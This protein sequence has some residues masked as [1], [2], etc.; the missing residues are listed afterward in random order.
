MTTPAEKSGL[1]KEFL[2]YLWCHKLACLL[3]LILAVLIL[4]GIVLLSD[5]SS[6]APFMY[7]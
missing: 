6:V 3:P 1:L 2:K 5:S 4:L 7:R